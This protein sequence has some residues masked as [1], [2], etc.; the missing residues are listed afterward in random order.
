ML[1]PFDYIMSRIVANTA[2]EG[3]CL[4]WKGGT[5]N[6][7]G[8]IS[9]AGKTYTI[10]RLVWIMFNDD[11]DLYV[12]HSC[13]NPPCWNIA[14]LFLGTALDNT[15]DMISKGRGAW[16]LMSREERISKYFIVVKNSGLYIPYRRQSVT[17]L[18]KRMGLC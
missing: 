15:Q 17:E 16:Q 9:F 13:D 14:H 4:V 18:N 6:G 5:S 10:H 1:E 3:R 7:Y 8:V 12:C 11:T 2:R